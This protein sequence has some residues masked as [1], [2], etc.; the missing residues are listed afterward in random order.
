[1]V[2]DPIQVVPSIPHRPTAGKPTTV[3]FTF[4]IAG[5]GGGADAFPSCTITFLIKVTHGN[6]VSK[7]IALLIGA[8]EYV[9]VIS[10]K[11]DPYPVRLIVLL[12]C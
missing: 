4:L 12:I 1:M 6:G 8:F 5:G 9:K 11:C 10:T 2:D 7:L 3:K